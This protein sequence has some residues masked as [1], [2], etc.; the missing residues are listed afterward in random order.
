MSSSLGAA[1]RSAFNTDTFMKLLLAQLKNQDPEAPTSQ[2]EM[3]SQISSMAMVEGMNNLNCSFSSVLKLQQMLS[4]EQ[5]IGREVQDLQ[6]GQTAQRHGA[7]HPDNRRRDDPDR[8]RPERAPRAGH[9]DTLRKRSNRYVELAPDSRP[10]YA[11]IPGDAQRG[12]QQPGQCGHGGLQGRPHM[13]L[14]HVQPH[15]H[16]RHALQRRPRRHGPRAGGPRRARLHHRQEHEPGQLH[17]HGQGLRPG[18]RRAG[19]LR[20]QRR[21]HRTSTPATAPSTST[22]TAT[23]S[24]PPRAT[25]SSASA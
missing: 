7:G 19:L 3:T 20:G 4:G 24:T 18:A 17:Q 1:V 25:A 13:L 8:R 5:M 9:E 10:G 6:S 12:R 16:A 14:G 11:G 15:P 2:A 21:H 23:W 22:P